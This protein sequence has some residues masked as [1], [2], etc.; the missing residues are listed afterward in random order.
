MAFGMGCCCLQ[1]TFQC[2]NINEA[3]LFYDHLAVL[4]PIM[5]SLTAA[6]PIF[7]GYL[8][9]TDVRWNV[10]SSSVDDRTDEE[11]GKKPLENDKF[12]INKSRYASA[13]LYINPNEEELLEDY[14]DLDV[15]YDQ[16]IFETL[17][18]EGFDDRLAKHFAHLFI[19]DPL[20]VYENGI[21]LDDTIH[22]DHFENIQS[23]NWQTVR[24]KPPP[25]KSDIGWRVEFRSMEASLTDFENAAFSIFVV[26]MTRVIS[27]FGL[28]FYMPLS[29]VDENM[30]SAHNRDS[31][32]NEKF[33]FRKINLDD[34]DEEV[35]VY[36]K[37][38][39]NEIMNGTEDKSNFVG[40]IPLVEI[41]LDTINTPK[42]TRKKIDQYLS[43]LSK[44]ASGELVTTAR[45]IRNFVSNH[46]KYTKNSVISHEI[47]H[48][49]L[50]ACY[51]ISNG[52]IHEESLFGD[53][54]VSGSNDNSNN[55]N[56]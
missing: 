2:C 18:N 51:K 15:A 43:L 35:P 25:P 33:Y 39:L 13:S 9:D 8:V 47:N 45:W 38:T 30:K 27:S 10:I 50:D 7:R 26:L 36:Q 44:R 41:Y 20:V 19:R 56:N 49:L 21:E 54:D 32:I 40:L 4:C 29:Y 16:S 24:F 5:L 17:K 52:L 23:T 46:P 34:D 6:A 22:S 11:R 53:L 12:V 48:D 1:T 14:N 55:N 31:V 42:E 28:N 3:R 37:Y